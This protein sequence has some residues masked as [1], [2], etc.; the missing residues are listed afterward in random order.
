MHKTA[1][2]IGINHYKFAPLKGCINDAQNMA[3]I[4]SK[5]YDGSPNFDTKT[6]V[7]G[8]VRTISDGYLRGE[9]EKLFKN[10]VDTALLYFSGHGTE[11]V[12]GGYLVTQGASATDPGVSFN[13]VIAYAN[14]S[15][16]P[17]IIIILDCCHSGHVANWNIAGQANGKSVAL[18]REGISILSA[19]RPEQLSLER[20]GEGLFTSIICEGLRGSAAD[21]TGK[22][23]VAGIYANAD[24]LLGPWDQRP[25]F[26]SHV[27][28]MKPMRYCEPRVDITILRKLPTYF[29][30]SD[31][32]HKLDPSYEPTADSIE[33]TN[34][35]IFAD[36]QKLTAASLV[37]PVGEEHMYYAAM[38][39]KSCRL[40]R[41]GTFYWNM[42]KE[43]RL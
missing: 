40:T 3:S 17:E 37:E 12:L 4:L 39:S 5:H 33:D 16:I 20:K 31:A 19:S 22:V 8:G 42:A 6:V 28:Q 15:P 1:L 25:V 36:L 34:E 29:T 10:R 27:E 30:K 23:T 2:L 11:N 13:D 38:N 26:K 41:L 14:H 24:H 32:E 7:S 35:E 43:G 18:L 9:I 21:I